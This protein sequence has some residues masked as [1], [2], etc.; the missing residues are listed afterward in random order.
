MAQDPVIRGFISRGSAFSIIDVLALSLH[1]GGDSELLSGLSLC[2]CL[3]W[4]SLGMEPMLASNSQSSCF[5]FLC[6]VTTNM[7][8][9]LGSLI[10]FKMA[11]YSLSN[12]FLKCCLLRSSS[13]LSEFQHTNFS[14]SRAVYIWQWPGCGSSWERVEK[15]S[16]HHYA[17]EIHEKLRSWMT[18]FCPAPEVFI[19]QP[20]EL[21]VGLK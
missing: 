1:C 20:T 5:N 6:V 10:L 9:H 12:N 17:R 16:S 4:Q 11:S 7:S 2:L 3:V 14:Q 19:Q 18:G 8:S 13:S 15:R 21:G